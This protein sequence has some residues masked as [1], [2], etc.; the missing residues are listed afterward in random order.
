M[1]WKVTLVQQNL[2]VDPT[3]SRRMQERGRLTTGDL[4]GAASPLTRLTPTVAHIIGGPTPSCHLQN[5]RVING[6]V[7]GREQAVNTD[8]LSRH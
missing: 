5:S 8:V 1:S 7:G 4:V 2:G 3:G 6:V